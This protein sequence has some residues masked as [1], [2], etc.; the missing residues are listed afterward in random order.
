MLN[1]GGTATAAAGAAADDDDAAREDEPPGPQGLWKKII[2]G[3]IV[4]VLTLFPAFYLLLF[5]VQQGK[6]MLKVW[7][8]SSM[9]GWALSAIC[10]EP[11]AIFVQVPCLFHVSEHRMVSHGAIFLG[12]AGLPARRRRHTPHQD[13]PSWTER[14]AAREGRPV[15]AVERDAPASERRAAA[16]MGQT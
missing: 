2:C 9:T 12:F 16:I 5:G 8:I 7:W 15:R 6:A 10:Y 3:V 11:F 4:V 13:R 14:A 1:D